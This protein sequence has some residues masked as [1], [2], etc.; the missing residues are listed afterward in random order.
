M[1][2]SRVCCTAVSGGYVAGSARESADEFPKL[3]QEGLRV[4]LY[5]LATRLGNNV[6]KNEVLARCSMPVVPPTKSS[7]HAG[8]DWLYD[9][10]NIS[11][12]RLFST[13]P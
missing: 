7:P 2:R 8:R 13:R 1:A 11:A 4:D 6:F 5:R 12:E 9:S 10:S 3:A